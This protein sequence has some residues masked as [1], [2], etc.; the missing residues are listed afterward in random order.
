MLPAVPE[1][2]PNKP[3]SGRTS[4]VPAFLPAF[5][6]AITR[7]PTASRGR[8]VLAMC[9]A[10][11][12]DLLFWWLGEGVPVVADFVVAF[13]IALCLGGFSVGSGL[14]QTWRP[15]TAT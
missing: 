14:S 15:V 9:V 3:A 13:V 10:L 1:I 2:P 8:F 4:S 11:A 12:A 6:G 7:P 5:L